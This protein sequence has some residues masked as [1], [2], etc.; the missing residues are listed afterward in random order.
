[1]KQHNETANTHPV[2]V[3]PVAAVQHLSSAIPPSLATARGH[4]VKF[5]QVL[6]WAANVGLALG[7]Q[8]GMRMTRGIE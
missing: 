7:G 1:M 8:N 2:A 3:R 5:D 4:L 6:A